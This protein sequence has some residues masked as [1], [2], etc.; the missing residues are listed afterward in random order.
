MVLKS[1]FQ[2]GQI[3]LRGFRE[4]D[5][6]LEV[7]SY[8][9]LSEQLGANASIRTAESHFTNPRILN[10]ADVALPGVQ[11]NEQ[12]IFILDEIFQSLDFIGSGNV[13]GLMEEAG[14]AN[15]AI[16]VLGHRGSRRQGRIDG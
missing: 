12:S 10:V 16:S 3:I 2:N 14:K 11:V 5:L 9:D 15:E 13:V 4:I 7:P 6:R 1:A 8:F